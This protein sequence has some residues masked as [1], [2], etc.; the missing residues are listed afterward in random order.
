MLSHLTLQNFRNYKKSSFDFKDKSLI[1]IGPNTAGKSNL[2]ES[3]FLLSTGKSFR[4]EKDSQMVKI[5]HELGKVKARVSDIDLEVGVTVGEVAGVRAQYKRFFVNGVAKRRADFVGNFPS[6]L[7]SPQDL[8]I[9]V[10]SP[11]LRRSFLDNVLDQTDRDYRI[12]SLG[13]SK[14]L[15]QRNA[16]LEIAKETGARHEKEFEYWDSLVIRNGNV[17]TRK[18]EEFINFLNESK[19]DIFDFKIEYDK[20]LISKERL[21][22]YRDAESATGVTLV[23]PHRDDFKILFDYGVGELV[24]LKSFGSRGQ[25]RLGVLQLKLLELSYVHDNIDTKPIFLL[26]D[27][28][29]E[30]D[31]GHINLILGIIDNQQ[32]IVTTTHEEF[33]P[34]KIQR[35]MEIIELNNAKV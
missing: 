22:Q 15:K 20:S 18:R 16:L 4:A 35:T 14:A 10:G 5:G 19:K 26:D 6:V 21:E 9:V 2:I 27:V 17:I 3:I 13:F 25:Q 34:A 23:G 24:E 33:I 28:F 1:I 29:S 32:T 11:G 12:A 8:E 31:E 7:F 30:L